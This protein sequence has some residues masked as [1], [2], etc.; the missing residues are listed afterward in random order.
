MNH[1][2]YKSANSKADPVDIKPLPPPGKPLRSQI[3][4]QIFITFYIFIVLPE[5]L[6]SFMHFFY[7]VACP[8]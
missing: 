4:A 5:K 1:R 6:D 8:K 7:S 2:K 3:W